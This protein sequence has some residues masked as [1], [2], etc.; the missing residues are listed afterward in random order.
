MTRLH[1]FSQAQLISL[2]LNETQGQ[3]LH[4]EF[5]SGPANTHCGLAGVWQTH[6]Q[7]SIPAVSVRF[8]S[9]HWVHG[10]GIQTRAEVSMHTHIHQQ[11]SPPI[12]LAS[13][14]ATEADTRHFKDEGDQ[15]DG[16]SVGTPSRH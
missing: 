4:G 1:S 13:D 8:G 10:T 14:E 15:A 12:F 7:P 11:A 9:E 3:T 6:N 2:S 16:C 5:V